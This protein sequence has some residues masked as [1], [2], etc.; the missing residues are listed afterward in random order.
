MGSPLYSDLFF[1]QIV[2]G[3]NYLP[4]DTCFKLIVS[5]IT[6]TIC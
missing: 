2:Q 5:L 6:Q 4:K 3:D 1:K